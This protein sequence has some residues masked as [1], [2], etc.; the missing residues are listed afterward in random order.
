MDGSMHPHDHAADAL[1]AHPDS[2]H[3][4]ADHTA[5]LDLMYA[6]AEGAGN[7]VVDV[8]EAVKDGLWSDPETWGGVDKM[9]K[10]NMSVVIPEG[11]SVLIDGDP[12]V[13]LMSVLVYGG[14]GFDPSADVTMY[15]DE[16][17][18]APSSVLHIGSPENP[19]T[20]DIDIIIRDDTDEVTKYERKLIDPDQLGKGIVT[21]GQ[22]R[23][24]GEEKTS[25][26]KV[27]VD[28]MAGDTSLTFDT[29]PLNWAAG[30]KIVI[31]GTHFNGAPGRQAIEN[32]YS[33]YNIWNNDLRPDQ[34]AE[35]LAD[36]PDWDPDAFNIW[37][38]S[39]HPKGPGD[40]RFEMEEF[41]TQ[42]EV[43]M[44]TGVTQNANGTWTV[45][46]DEALVHDH[47][48]PKDTGANGD[49]DL[50]A[51]IANYSRNVTISSEV[52][53]A[54]PSDTPADA[55]IWVD[56]DAGFGANEIHD[57]GHVMF[58]HNP[59]VQVQNA[60][61]A[62]LGRTDKNKP[63]DDLNWEWVLA[64]GNKE[65]KWTA[66]A[67][68]TQ[69]ED[70]NPINA[71]DAID[72]DDMLVENAAGRY[73]LHFHQTG[74]DPS[75]DAALA[76]GNAVWGSPGWGIVH[77][78][79][80][81]NI[82]DNA[83]FGIR[84]GGIVSETGNETG[85]WNGNIVVKTTGTSDNLFDSGGPA[86]GREHKLDDTF[87]GGDA[88][89]FESRLIT[90][91]GNI[92]V[93]AQ[94]FG[95]K[96]IGARSFDSG[97]PSADDFKAAQGYDPFWGASDID[98]RRVPNRTFV[99]NEGYANDASFGSTLH[100]V[101]PNTMAQS[102]IDGFVS[103]HSDQG[104]QLAYA[105]GYAFTNNLY[106]GDPERT[107]ESQWY[108]GKPKQLGIDPS[109]DTGLIR[110]TNSHFENL[111]ED[112]T[113]PPAD[114]YAGNT[115]K[116]VTKPF[117]ENKFPDRPDGHEGIFHQESNQGKAYFGKLLV[118]DLD[119]LPRDINHM[120]FV[121]DGYEQDLSIGRGDSKVVLRG[122]ME[123]ALIDA[124]YNFD[125]N[126]AWDNPA[127]HV[128][129]SS[130]GEGTIFS[131]NASF[132]NVIRRDGYYTD[133]NGTK[134][135][136]VDLAMSSKVTGSVAVKKVAIDIADDYSI[137]P[138][139][140]YMGKL[141]DYLEFDTS[142]VE[143]R[144]SKTIMIDLRIPGTTG[145]QLTDQQFAD[146]IA[147]LN[148]PPA[149]GAGQYAWQIA[150]NYV[151]LTMPQDGW[152]RFDNDHSDKSSSEMKLFDTDNDR[153]GSFQFHK[154]TRDEDLGNGE[155]IGQAF[156]K[157]GGYG[158]TAKILAMAAVAPLEGSLRLVDGG[159]MGDDFIT[160][161]V[162]TGD[163]WDF[164]RFV[165]S[166]VENAIA[167][168]Y[169]DGGAMPLMSDL[170][171]A[172]AASD[173][174][175]HSD[176]M[177]DGHDHDDDMGGD[178]TT[179]D[180][181]DDYGDDADD[182]HDHG[183]DIGDDDDTP[184]LAGFQA[185]HLEV[186]SSV[187]RLSDIDFSQDAVFEE[188]VNEIQYDAG[189]AN[190]FYD[191]GRKDNFAVEFTGTLMIETAGE[192]TFWLRSDDGSMLTI[193]DDIL[194]NDGLHAARTQSFKLNLEAGA[195]PIEVLY[196]ER[197]GHAVAELDWA[198]PDTDGA[199][200]AL[201]GSAVMTPGGMDDDYGDDASDGMDDTGSGHDHG[202]DMS[203]DH[204]HDDGMGS[205]DQM[206]D[207]DYSGDHGDDGGMDAG[208]T[209]DMPVDGDPTASIPRVVTA[210]LND[211]YGLGN[212]LG[213]E[214]I[215][216][217][218]DSVTFSLE[219]E[220]GAF[221]YS[222]AAVEDIMTSYADA[223]SELADHMNV[224][225]NSDLRH[226]DTDEDRMFFFGNGTR[227]IDMDGNGTSLS[228]VTGKGL[229]PFSRH[230][231]NFDDFI[232][233]V[234]ENK[235]NDE[236]DVA[237]IAGGEE[238]DDFLTVEIT[239]VWDKEDKDALI[240]EGQEVEDAIADFYAQDEMVF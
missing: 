209:G 119:D 125:Y 28:P 104:V 40:W 65:L 31:T 19:V 15:V 84:G 189:R 197:G 59:D 141:P 97:N 30:D 144:F 126:A 217:T 188:V 239:N 129:S 233:T 179:G 114:V 8:V 195:H 130:S 52:A 113:D 16:I 116:N 60:E 61:F 74:T 34:I 194:G 43:R 115:T 182:D 138:M 153:L 200:V 168:Y 9:P 171:F 156:G 176:D 202:D 92:A 82:I 79:S 88:F 128:I 187:R 223:F 36:D 100:K 11:V 51:S 3:L 215:S 181:G 76:E 85:Q 159:M 173:S 160:V 192:Y 163:D 219:G 196:F 127:Y 53:H 110:V 1:E 143:G 94:S 72:R 150:D 13:K 154:E 157:F 240:I 112:F 83:V 71:R 123:D 190:A 170:P 108:Q 57:R 14:L 7:G 146:A 234:L 55:D 20:G 211:R 45:S 5:L 232:H 63:L 236:G 204:D 238:G 180:A 214:F 68:Q 183:G 155:T 148:P 44:V 111:H 207:D 49:V 107:S 213:V 227:E 218:E 33:N 185:R 133:E 134:Y 46:F 131:N 229:T 81:L 95:Y 203:S 48:A 98:M 35:F 62:G 39:T 216:K 132:S 75:V 99:D 25:H 120:D 158:D 228:D 135:V 70:G 124:S 2:P 162:K 165:G 174:H 22:V 38:A 4:H 117:S 78:D 230:N 118:E 17:L 152:I 199:R 106:V 24:E 210:A 178:D 18:T 56:E 23:I 206:G 142:T 198:G 21:H 169:A 105:R 222:G 184:S 226:F 122:I 137:P 37:D 221:V 67:M 149:E 102:T 191:G 145:N 42:D 225:R 66:W 27:S 91:E 50:F 80:H 54:E 29:E 139:A 89:G 10:E 77:H 87:F 212:D 136:L 161:L 69:D 101:F 205:G 41:V 201:D 147:E 208:D 64:T 237:L 186:S 109:T 26:L 224:R 164:A 32:S 47:D 172:Q 86:G 231:D 12:G 6:R 175:D 167:D 177:G 93:S 140:K 193:G 58:M 103:W 73:A 151:A 121:I 90:S 96:F 166:D 235:D 220:D